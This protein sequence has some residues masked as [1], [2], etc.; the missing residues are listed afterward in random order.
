[1]VDSTS[2]G[3]VLNSLWFLSGLITGIEK[4]S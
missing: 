4:L 3:A 2:G 1:M